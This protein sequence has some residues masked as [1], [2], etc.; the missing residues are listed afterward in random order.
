MTVG[1]VSEVINVSESAISLKTEEASL[2]TTIVREQITQLPLVGRQI[3]GATLLA[4]GAYFVNNNSKAQRDS[5]FV[6][7][8]GLSLSVNGLTDLSNK[9]APSTPLCAT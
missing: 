4:P 2:S 6:R 5:G 1:Q 9:G 3:N 7:R 8:N